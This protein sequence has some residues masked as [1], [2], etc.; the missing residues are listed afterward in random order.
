MECRRSLGNLSRN[1]NFMTDAI[2]NIHLVSLGLIIIAIYIFSVVSGISRGWENSIA[3]RYLCYRWNGIQR[4]PRRVHHI[5]NTVL[6]FCSNKCSFI[7]HYG[8][9]LILLLYY[10][11][12][13]CIRYYLLLYMVF[14]R[15]K[16]FTLYETSHL[17][18]ICSFAY[19]YK[20]CTYAQRLY[21]S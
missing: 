7:A 2:L 14:T 15:P 19:T 21:Q 6:L 3:G 5:L 9:W 16:H 20:S 13:I 1:V 4:V 10:F 18:T 11:V 12:S 8:I 17:I